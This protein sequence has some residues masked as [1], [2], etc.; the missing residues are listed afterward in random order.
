MKTIH[1]KAR[2][3]TEELR[4]WAESVECT[5]EMKAAA[6]RV[7]EKVRELFIAQLREP[8]RHGGATTGARHADLERRLKKSAY[9]FN[10]SIIY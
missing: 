6:E 3:S 10:S 2:Y 8:G 4:K 1:L 9:Y 5:E 7:G